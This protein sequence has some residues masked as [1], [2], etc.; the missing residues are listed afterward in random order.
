M[1]YKLIIDN[2]FIEVEE[3]ELSQ[4]SIAL[5]KQ[6][7]ALN[8]P[9]LY[10][11]EWSKT[12]NIPFTQRNNRIFANIFRVDGLITNL[13][14]DPRKKIDFILLYNEEIITC[15]YCKVTNIYNDIT[16]KYYQVN[17]FSTLGNLLNEIK[18][19]TFFTN[20]NV[21]SKYIISNPLSNNLKI[22]RHLIKESFEKEK[23]NITNKSDLDYIGFVP[24][25]QGKYNNFESGKYDIN[26]D[27][28][29]NPYGEQDEHYMREFRSYYQ[30]PYIWVNSLFQLVKDKLESI[31]DYN[32]VLDRSFFNA[33]NPYWTNTIYTCPSLFNENSDNIDSSTKEKYGVYNQQ[34][35]SQTTVLNDCSN[36]HTKIIPF[37]RSSGN[38]IYDS[39]TKRFTPKGD[40]THFKESVVWWLFASAPF[41]TNSN[42]YCKLREDNALYLKFK[43]VNANTNRDIVG[44]EKVFCFYDGENNRTNFDVGIE[45]DVTNRDYPRAVMTAEEGVTDKDKGF[46]WSGELQIE[47]DVNTP[48]PFYIVCDN[49]TANNS[50]PFETAYTSYTPHWDWMWVDLWD[51]KGFTWYVSCVRAEVEN[52]LNIRSNSAITMERIWSKDV[53]IYDVII[54]F[55][56][57]FH[58]MFDL[59]ENSK[60]LT[61]T[62]RDRYFEPYSV[63]DWTDKIDR[64]KDYIL[65]PIWFDKKYLNFKYNDG[66]G[67]RFEYYQNKYKQSYGEVKVNTGYDFSTDEENL[68][69]NLNP[70][71]VCSKKQSSYVINTNNPEHANFKGYGY[72]VLPKEVYIENDNNGNNANNFGAFY[73]HNG[74]IQ[75]DSSLSAKDENNLPFMLISDDSTQQIKKGI[76]CWGGNQF[77]ITN[78]IPLI[79]T[80]SADGK[81]SIHFNEPKEIYFNKEVIP[82]DN[83]TYI[84]DGYWEKYF[85]ERYNVQNKMLTCYLYLTPTDYKNFKFNQ[86]IKLDNLIYLVNKITD[87]DMSTKGSTKVELLQIYD[88][89]AYTNSNIKQPYLYTMNDTLHVTE[90]VN[91]EYVY[92]TSDWDVMRKPFWLDVNIKD[93]YIEYT[94]KSSTYNTDRKGNIQ[95]KN[96]EGLYYFI[97]VHQKSTISY[98]TTIPNNIIFSGNGGSQRISLN[99]QPNTI[100]VVSK[101]DWCNVQIQ[102]VLGK[103]SLIISVNNN[104]LIS[105]NGSIVISNG[106]VESK[107]I[108][109][110]QGNR[111]ITATFNN[112]KP[113]D[114]SK[115]IILSETNE[116]NIT[117]NIDKEVNW[118]TLTSTTLDITKPIKK[119]GNINVTLPKPIKTKS[120]EQSDLGGIIKV[121]QTDNTYLVLDYN[122]GENLKKYL[123]YIDGNVIVDNINYYPFYELVEENTDLVVTA[124][125]SQGKIFLEW[126]DGNKDITRTLTVNSDIHIYPIFKEEEEKE[127]YLYDNDELILFDN[128]EIITY[129]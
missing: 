31:T 22:N 16:N 118:E 53:S 84:Y 65:Q 32:L 105:R 92:S 69:E 23:C 128:N 29:E 86:F 61:I 122:I 43:A 3:T 33:N 4:V 111:G 49:Y 42:D 21:D 89:E 81:L 83:P 25:Y 34:Y 46:L 2:N 114:I 48:E 55:C 19:F 9:T 129:I 37:Q 94:A 5:N 125:E 66:K 24:S 106:V 112:D 93:G 68:I 14:I 104:M 11:T 99:T 6:Y 30:M 123:V 85:D 41:E 87:F 121:N 102:N 107:I 71:M 79:S 36:H 82:Y 10:F 100:T 17:L 8:N 75:V 12:V 44:A 1:R 88:L 98:L 74:T 39:Q 90:E 56:K 78:K 115:P 28:I 72:K 20:T 101:P 97:Q 64:N 95:L 70:S 27:I 40:S 110:Q 117:F 119:I 108:V 113:I 57:M 127:G 60:T 73:F 126:S 67:Q 77:V 54:N 103:Y 96:R 51:S 13:N 124:I 7:E 38:Y 116:T 62:T 50:K 109:N 80:Y 76:Y 59:D 120:T 63:T 35:K 15:G 91:K 52:Q 18:Q 47:F 45:L 58:L 26:S